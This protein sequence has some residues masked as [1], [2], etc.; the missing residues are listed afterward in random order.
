MDPNMKQEYIGTDG[1]V[2]FVSSWDSNVRNVGKGSQSIKKIVDGERI[3]YNIHFIKPFEGIA[4][5]YMKTEH[6]SENQT[7]VIWGFRSRMN[8]P[9]NLMLLFMNMDKMVGNDLATGLTNLK[10][11]LEK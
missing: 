1:T 11:V 2:G 7:K 6:V 4:S 5:A 8:Y 3:E 10:G 9:M